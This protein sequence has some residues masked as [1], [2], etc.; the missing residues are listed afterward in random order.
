MIAVGPLSL[1]QSPDN[2]VTFL[3]LRCRLPLSCGGGGTEAM[4]SIMH[5]ETIARPSSCTCDA[6]NRRTQ[7][8][9]IGVRLLGPGQICEQLVSA[10]A[11]SA[12]TPTEQ[13]ARS[14]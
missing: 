7:S 12:R 14:S 10:T 5:D 2:F 1:A 13:T 3:W 6:P 9:L 4:R 11:N 8:A